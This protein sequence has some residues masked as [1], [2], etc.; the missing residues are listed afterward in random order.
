MKTK[1]FT[2]VELLVVIAVIL[3]LAGLLVPAVN[4][5][6]KKAEMAKAKAAI[7]TLYNAIKQYEST[8]GKLPIASGVSANALTDAQYQWLIQLLQGD[9]SIS[10]YT[11]YNP[12]N[13][14]FLEVQGNSP[15]VYQD[16][17]DQRLQVAF[18]HDYNGQI[19][20]SSSG[21][22]IPGLG[23]TIYY[24]VVIWSIGPDGDS[25]SG[26]DKK[27][28]DNVYSFNT[29]WDKANNRVTITK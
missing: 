8:Y 1:G 23:S 15:G 2:L 21:A 19:D 28:A 22:S 10:D 7:T 24:S 5:A 12:K 27:N 16:P 25:A 9:S 18:D 20:G 26:N 13:I 17:W 14:R 4:G 3:V 29:T 11:T 6:I